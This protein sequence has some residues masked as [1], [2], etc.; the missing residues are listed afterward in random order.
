MSPEGVQE[1]DSEELEG[2][3]YTRSIGEVSVACTSFV[4][5]VFLLA[6]HDVLTFSSDRSGL[7]Q[8]LV[9][10]LPLLPLDI[11]DDLDEYLAKLLSVLELL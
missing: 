2:R 3:R 4:F 1:S 7:E 11:G 5:L 8:G 9:C 6:P 10:V